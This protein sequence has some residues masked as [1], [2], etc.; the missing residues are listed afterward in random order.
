MYF[1]FSYK[2]KQDVTRL[3]YLSPVLSLD[4]CPDPARLQY[5]MFLYY[6]DLIF[7]VT[8][9]TPPGEGNRKLKPSNLWQEKTDAFLHSF[10]KKAVSVGS[11]AHNSR[12]LTVV[13]KYLSSNHGVLYSRGYKHESNVGVF[14]AFALKK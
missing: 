8:A 12:T 13:T 4:H 9:Q 10:F 14:F 11:T 7:L 5:A 6:F 3:S 2:N 1:S